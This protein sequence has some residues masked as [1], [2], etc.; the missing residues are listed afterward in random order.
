L[1]QYTIDAQFIEGERNLGGMSDFE[2]MV[3]PRIIALIGASD[4]EGPVGKA[5]LENL[6]LFKSGKIYL[7]NPS[8][9]EIL[10][11]RRYPP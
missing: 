5:I 6:L 8:T 11:L 4:K 9:T 7:V 3:N 10:G 2:L 1:I